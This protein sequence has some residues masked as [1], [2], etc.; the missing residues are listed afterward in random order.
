MELVGRRTSEI[1]QFKAWRR[2]WY[3]SAPD[4]ASL[5][6]PGML[7]SMKQTDLDALQSATGATFDRLVLD[8]MIAHEQ[9]AI[10]MAQSASR[11]AFHPQLGTAARA[12]IAQQR[13]ELAR[14]RGWQ[15]NA[16]RR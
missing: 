15:E 11:H 1:E 13:K 4:A 2:A 8:M 3:G 10:D 14:L 12:L 9:G 16:G 7:S 5:R 6:M